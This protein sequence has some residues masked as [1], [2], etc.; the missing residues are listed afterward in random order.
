MK[1][2][3]RCVNK[4]LIRFLDMES[5]CFMINA[6]RFCMHEND[7]SKHI[8]DA[9]IAVHKE[10][11]GPGLLESCYEAALVQELR[12]RGLSVERQ[13]PIQLIYKGKFLDETYR[14]DLVVEDKVIVECK[15]VERRNPIFAAQLLTYLKIT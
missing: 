13:K 3:W 6:E 4:L 1:C 5:G 12:S 8:L 2:L 14:V 15:A 9:A 7:I 11:G 10:F